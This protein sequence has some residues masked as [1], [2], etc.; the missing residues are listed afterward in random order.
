MGALKY[1]LKKICN[2]KGSLILCT[3]RWP[4]GLEEFSSGGAHKLWKY[5]LGVTRNTYH[6]GNIETDY[7]VIFL[8]SEDVENHL[9]FPNFTTPV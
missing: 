9:E 4:D 3:Y 8:M 6:A 5:Y 1:P 7:R 2:I